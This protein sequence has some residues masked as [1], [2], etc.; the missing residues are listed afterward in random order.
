MG[1]L[2]HL[3]P[4]HSNSTDA[5]SADRMLQ[6]QLASARKTIDQHEKNMRETLAHL[7][8]ILHPDNYVSAKLEN[9]ILTVTHRH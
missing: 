4:R 6:K 7:E 2:K 5:E 3:L 9:G 8:Y 1:I